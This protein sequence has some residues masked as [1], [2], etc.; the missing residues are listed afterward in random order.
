MAQSWYE[1]LF[2]H[3][4]LAPEAL[5]PLIPAALTID[6]FEHEAWIG[7]V[8]FRMSGVRPRGIP[9]MRGLSAFPELNVR[10]YVTYQGIPGV[11]FF[12]LDAGNPIAVTL[13]RRFFHL[14]YFNADMHCTQQGNTIDYYSHRTHRHA[15]AADFRAHYRPISPATQSTHDSLEYW[16][17]ERYCLYTTIGMEICRAN[18]HHRPWELQRAE[19]ETEMNTMAQAHTI[20]LP[21]TQP[22]L[23]YSARQDVLVW[24]LQHIDK[25]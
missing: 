1:L 17:T 13:A 21:T 22:L 24:P 25:V 3:W 19:L 11:F 7:I 4:P 15:P 18:I 8:P 23:H 20:Q 5:R 2:A 6:T 16:L 12:S 9:A 10:T 14:P